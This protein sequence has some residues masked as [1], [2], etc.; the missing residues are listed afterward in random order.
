MPRQSLRRLQHRDDLDAWGRLLTPLMRPSLAAIDDSRGFAEGTWMAWGLSSRSW[1]PLRAEQPLA[2]M[3]ARVTPW[4]TPQEQACRVLNVVTCGHA[5]DGGDASITRAR[6]LLDQVQMEALDAGLDGVTITSSASGGYH[7]QINACL[8]G[9]PGWTVKPGK[10]V[11]HL[12]RNKRTLQL[13]ERLE[14]AVARSVDARS[15][16]ME[17]YP[18]DPH[19]MQSRIDESKRNGWGVPWDPGD[20]TYSWTPAWPHCRVIRAGNKIIGWLICHFVRPDL[21][22]YAKL[23]VDPGWELSGVPLAMLADVIRRAHFEGKIS[24]GCFISHPTNE[25]LNRFVSRKFR[26]VADRWVDTQHHQLF[27]GLQG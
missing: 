9:H 27:F 10:T 12:S 3:L 15:W 19:E 22:R 21:L 16:S 23:W 6:L 1:N 2:L 25:R 14:R 24:S 7:A 8:A 20:D 18:R 11:V 17:P 26:P 5:S 13:L 4:L